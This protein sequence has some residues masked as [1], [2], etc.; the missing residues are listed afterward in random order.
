MQFK[1]DTVSTFLA[2]FETKKQLIRNFN[3]CQHLALWQDK[4][5]PTIL[6]TYSIWDNEAALNQYRFSSFFKATWMETKVLFA[7][8]AQAWSV[9]QLTALQ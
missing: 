8:K 4:N 6:F 1:A 3:G 5:D 7:A 9:N 2:L